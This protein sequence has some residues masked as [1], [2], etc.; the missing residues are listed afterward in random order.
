MTSCV[1]YWN[2]KQTKDSHFPFTCNWGCRPDSASWFLNTD[3]LRISIP[4]TFLYSKI[5][6]V[7]RG[8]TGLKAAFLL[9][10]R[11][12]IILNVHFNSKTREFQRYCNIW[13]NVECGRHLQYLLIGRVMSTTGFVFISASRILFMITASSG[14]Q[15]FQKSLP[16][17]V[18]LSAICWKMKKTIWRDRPRQNYKNDF[19]QWSCAVLTDSYSSVKDHSC[20]LRTALPTPILQLAEPCNLLSR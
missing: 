2:C 13:I 4:A 10:V 7:L 9:G 12:S 17:G 20:R 16:R 14:G 3:P 5:L 1:P 11:G 19:C 15:V 18:P 8:T 6:W